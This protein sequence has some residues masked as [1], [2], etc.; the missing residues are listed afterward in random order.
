MAFLMSLGV[1]IEGMTIAAF[2]ILLFG[3]KQR[4]EQGWAVLSIMVAIAAVVQAGSMSLTVCA[5][6][7]L[8][9]NGQGTSAKYV[10][11]YLY[12]NDPRFFVGWFLD[13][14][15]I[16]CTVSWSL[17]A[18]CAIAI[19]TAALTLPSEGGYELIPDNA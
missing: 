2:L 11:A 15:W 3:G 8:S 9:E 1:V 13:K 16:M 6:A 18:F 7:S 10:Q 4:R 14:S 17:Q 19:T 5:T 12:D